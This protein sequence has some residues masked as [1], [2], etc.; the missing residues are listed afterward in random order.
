MIK[1]NVVIKNWKTGV[2]VSTYSNVTAD[3]LAHLE[4]EHH[5]HAQAAWD[6]E[7]TKA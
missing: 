5:A 6:L 1:Y 2:I 7:A 4:A 3:E